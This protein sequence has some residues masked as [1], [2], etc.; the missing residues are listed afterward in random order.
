M[1]CLLLTIVI[2][3]SFLCSGLEVT[4]VIHLDHELD[5][6]T[7]RYHLDLWLSDTSFTGS[8]RKLVSLMATQHV[9]ALNQLVQSISASSN[10]SLPEF[11]GATVASEQELHRAKRNVLGDIIH[12]LTGLATDDEVKEQIRLDKELKQQV[13]SLMD[14]QLQSEKDL[15][16]AIQS[17]EHEEE[18]I[19]RK[20]AALES[21]L[22]TVS[23]SHVRLLYYTLLCDQD[24]K[25]LSDTLS[26]VLGGRTP[27]G[28]SSYLSRKAGL[29]LVT[30]FVYVAVHPSSRGWRVEYT[31]ELTSSKLPVLVTS[32]Y[33][34]GAVWRGERN[35]FL[36]RSDIPIPDLL[37]SEVRLHSRSCSECAVLVHVATRSYHVVKSGSI[38]CEYP[39]SQ[40]NVLSLNVSSY[41]DLSVYRGCANLAISLG[42]SNLKITS[43]RVSTASGSS[44]LDS[45]LLRRDLSAGH[46]PAPVVNPGV[47]S[48][49]LHKISEDLKNT[50]VN[51]S[52]FS[53]MPLS[54]PTLGWTTLSNTGVLCFVF[55]V[56]MAF[57]IAVLRKAFC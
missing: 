27:P 15:L 42:E 25:M 19:D 26:A 30:T 11:K 48:G 43:Y 2:T 46:R 20:L 14:H 50:K 5:L 10:M 56:L 28:L 17:V 7:M 52:L 13:L 6:K 47:H 33:L 39:T 44:D 18:E 9:L 23:S 21:R 35:E 22:D 3:R 38:T 53:E 34:S 31:S 24:L 4:G 57:T 49:L 36:I 55:L 16:D 45:L 51:I 29:P 32:N 1:L 41:I 12:T 37:M 8:T 54:P 40:I